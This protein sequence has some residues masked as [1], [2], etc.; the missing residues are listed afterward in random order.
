METV[1]PTVIDLQ[2]V[3][4]LAKELED[5]LVAI[6][7]EYHKKLPYSPWDCHFNFTDFAYRPKVRIMLNH[8]CIMEYSP[9][10]PSSV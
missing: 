8:E 10:E 5:K 3:N 1:K 2:L 4:S 9:G 7:E 6:A